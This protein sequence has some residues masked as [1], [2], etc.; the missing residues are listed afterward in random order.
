[1]KLGVMVRDK[2]TDATGV[3]TGKS[4]YLYG[5]TLW[6]FEYRSID[7]AICSSWFPEERFEVIE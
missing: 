4:E 6:Q 3:I 7:G 1:M 2:V 5:E